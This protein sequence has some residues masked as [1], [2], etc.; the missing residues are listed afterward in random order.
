MTSTIT[1]EIMQPFRPRARMLQL[2]GD[3]LIATDRLAVFELVK[4]AYDADAN[5]VTVSL[6]LAERGGP[7][8]ITVVDDGCGMTLE[9]IQAI[10][11]VPG[12]EH[13]KKQRESLQR[14]PVHHRLPLGEKGVGRFAV[15]K[16]GDHIRLITRARDSNE[17]VV[18]IDWNELIAHP[19]L[20]EAPV[21]ISVRHPEVFTNGC[22]GT[23]IRVGQLRAEWK[24]G[25]V[26][27][28]HN[29]ITSICSPFDEPGS[30]GAILNAPKNESWLAGLPDVK[31]IL[32]HAFWKFSFVLA[33]GKFDWEYEFRKIPGLS[34]EAR[35]T[36]GVNEK[37][38]LPSTGLEERDSDQV[39][40]DDTTTRGIGPIRGELYV[41]DRDRRILS[42]LPHRQMIT[43]YLDEAG[44]VRVYRDGIRV[45]NYG[46]KGDDWLGLDL[47][48]VNTPARRIS[49]NIVLGAIHLTL[50]GSSGL[51]EK[52]NR[53]GFVDNEVSQ[54]LQRIA[55]G[56]VGTL[57]AQRFPD[58]SRMRQLEVPQA[59]I[60]SDSVERL[61][62]EAMR[63]FEKS[64]IEDPTIPSCLR[65]IR[66]Y[67]REM[68]DTLLS[69]GLSG[70]NLAVVFHEVE[71]GVRTLHEALVRGTEPNA[72]VG[73]AR[74]LAQT[75][76]GFS[77]LLRRNT[78]DRHSGRKLVEAALRISSL[79]LDYHQIKVVCPLLEGSDVG[80][81]SKFAFN[82]VLG[83]LSN[84]IDNAIYWLRV[85]HSDA[86]SD[87]APNQRMLYIGVTDGFEA[88]PG[89]V[90]ADNGTGFQAET[91]EFITHPF[92][93]HKPE[94]MGLGLYYA[95]LAME[96]QGGQLGFPSRE[97]VSVP[98]EFDG[99]VV[100]MVFKED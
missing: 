12:N 48:R 66:R 47:R 96:Q 43:N 16:L 98:D 85:R 25:E 95:R 94:G 79:R 20:D 22:T 65:R 55:L 59:G 80:F 49:R 56:V 97:E 77:A 4:N 44:G 10:W 82:L 42:H 28:L 71:R 29:Q 46:E 15:H 45:Y 81:H 87:R 92:Y 86:D 32:S 17:C 50:E 21:K 84:L 63:A 52:T 88:G 61:V 13:R 40:A 23:Q 99:A 53:E 78:I 69:A 36:Q 75:L 2:L 30:F 7:K 8:N 27:R 11:L 60:S 51:V 9:D 68:Q 89:I 72:L 24:R 39:V 91:R 93:T 5:S 14:T 70:L 90:V 57:E 58:K 33:N 74:D 34:L 35:K 64:G 67:H 6:N 37:L 3:E 100:A 26:R 54:R 1:K 76:D 31:A 38:Q 73:Q 19:Y 83:A 18:D 62:D 41:Y